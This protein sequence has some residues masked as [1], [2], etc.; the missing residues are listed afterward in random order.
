MR[1]WDLPWIVAGLWRTVMHPVLQGLQGTM[2]C[3]FSLHGASRCLPPL[4]PLHSIAGRCCSLLLLWGMNKFTKIRS[5]VLAFL[6][7]CTTSVACSHFK[8]VCFPHSLHLK[9]YS[10]LCSRMRFISCPC[11]HQF[12][13]FH[14]GMEGRFCAYRNISS[15]VCRLVW[16]SGNTCLAQRP[17]YW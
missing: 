17:R 9:P 6:M 8:C 10:A 13:L 3:G 7:L 1:V 16:H 15:P 5:L 12:L 2:Q 11:E 4:C 14:W